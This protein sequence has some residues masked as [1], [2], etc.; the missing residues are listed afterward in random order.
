MA[1]LSSDRVIEQDPPQSLDAVDGAWVIK[2]ADGEEGGS[3]RCLQREMRGSQ[4][5]LSYVACM[6][7]DL[8][9]A[10]RKMIGLD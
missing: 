1:H 4:W 6:L 5:D 7:I 8:K 10:W 3:R 2:G 9:E